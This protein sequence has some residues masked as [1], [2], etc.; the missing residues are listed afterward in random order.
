MGSK[1]SNISAKAALIMN[2][3]FKVIRDT[4]IN[5]V[6]MSLSDLQKV[7]RVE[8]TKNISRDMKTYFRGYGISF[9][10]FCSCHGKSSFH[11]YNINL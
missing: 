7:L 4:G 2:N 3:I 1:S 10:V 9:I 6:T 11:L 8:S 5:E